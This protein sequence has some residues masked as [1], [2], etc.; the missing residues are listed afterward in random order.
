M[1]RRK[2][3]YNT[4]VRKGI[5]YLLTALIFLAGPSAYAQKLPRNLVADLLRVPAGKSIPAAT[6]KVLAGLSAQQ[7]TLLA[8][9]L[10]QANTR[11]AQQNLKTKTIQKR[12]YEASRPAVFRALPDANGPVNSYTGT[13]FEV[14]T[15]GEKEIF[16]AIPMHALKN[17]YKRAGFVP[18]EFTAIVEQEGSFHT[19]PARVEQISTSKM[20]DVAL[21]KFRQEDE[22]LLSPLPLA[23]GEVSFDQPLYAQGYACN[24]HSQALV[25]L[26][27]NTSAGMLTTRIPAAR[28]GERVGFCGSPLVNDKLELAAFHIGS[29]YETEAS[30]EDAFFNVF[31]LSKPLNGDGGYAVPASFLRQ[32]VDS[33]HHPGK[34]VVPVYLLDQ[35]ITRLPVDEYISRIEILDASH[36]VLWHKNTEQKVSLRPLETAL[37]LF[38]QARWARLLIG[39]TYW[40]HDG[41]DWFV[42][43]DNTLHRVVLVRLPER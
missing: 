37:L 33:Y 4:S 31:G 1:L 17:E 42:K 5:I 7:R 35:E 40:Q 41:Y 2:K 34:A 11:L 21:V 32:M 26:S 22:S 14:D 6:R 36:Q 3:S 12:I 9:Q 20:G 43:N 18:N 24:L 8:R 16:G 13:V 23:E 29:V 38:P 27:G 39:K 30:K 19:V 28:A 10:S 25:R 15:D